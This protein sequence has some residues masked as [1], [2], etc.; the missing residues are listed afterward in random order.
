MT[1]E[2]KKLFFYILAPILGHCLIISKHKNFN[3]P[4]PV[5]GSLLLAKQLCIAPT[6]ISELHKI[7]NEIQKNCVRAGGLSYKKAESYYCVCNYCSAKYT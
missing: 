4:T 6:I 1:K 7:V 5:F 3:F 2:L